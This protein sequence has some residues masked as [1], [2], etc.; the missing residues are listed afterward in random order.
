MFRTLPSDHCPAR[1]NFHF[2]S[3]LVAKPE[4]CKVHASLVH[5]L[6]FDRYIRIFA[7]NILYISYFLR[8][9]ALCE[10]LS[11]S[12]YCVYNG[13]LEHNACKQGLCH[14]NSLGGA[15]H[16]SEF[17]PAELQFWDVGQLI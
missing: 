3:D 9:E 4:F 2:R 11:C 5:L 17:S 8:K 6:S 15:K 1:N 13:G 7:G 14:R 16:I 10:I 12:G